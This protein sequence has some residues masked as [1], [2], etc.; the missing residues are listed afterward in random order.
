M[1][2]YPALNGVKPWKGPEW[3]TNQPRGTQAFYEE[4]MELR[5]QGLSLRAI[6]LQVNLSHAGVWK[7][8]RRLESR[9]AEAHENAGHHET[10][11]TALIQT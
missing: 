4:I 10:E 8:L 2:E 11:E 7:A 1:A 3:P 5:Q 9:A 6:A